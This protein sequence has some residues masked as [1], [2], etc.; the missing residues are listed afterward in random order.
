MLKRY[1]N[2]A[3]R[4]FAPAPA[5]L[6]FLLLAASPAL[7]SGYGFGSS[8]TFLDSI[9]EWIGLVDIDDETA[10]V[11]AAA[12]LVF[13]GFFGYFSNMAIKDLGFG[14]VLER[15]HRR[16]R[17]LHRPSLRLAAPPPAGRLVRRRRVSVWG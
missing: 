5:S 1:P 13:A 16:R 6:A 11:F 7:A 2:N 17:N 3:L 9:I 15:P 4:L 12:M 14:I 8:H 10:S